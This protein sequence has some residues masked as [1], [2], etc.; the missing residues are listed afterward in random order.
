MPEPAR[1]VRRPGND[2]L[3]VPTEKVHPVE[4]TEAPIA[5]ESVERLIIPVVPLGSAA[6]SLPGSIDASALSTE[7][8]GPGDGGGTGTGVGSGDGPGRGSGLGDGRDRGT[9]GD[10][11]QPGDDVFPPVEIYKGSP[12]YTADA[13]RARAQGVILVECVVQTTGS[14]TNIQVKRSFNPAF[15]LD[16]EAVKAAAL[17]RFRP[18]MRRGQPVAVLVTMEIAFVLR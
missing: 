15:G 1:V 2:A 5:R 11:Y 14:C 17:W 16:Q 6:V 9:G 18:G 7:S 10:V 3:S 12:Q 8:Q 4:S 13:M